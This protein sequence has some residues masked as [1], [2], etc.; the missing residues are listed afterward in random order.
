[1]NAIDA[2]SKAGVKDLEMFEKQ[3]VKYLEYKDHPSKIKE[4]YYLTELKEVKTLNARQKEAIFGLLGTGTYAKRE[5]ELRTLSSARIT[6]AA[7][8]KAYNLMRDPENKKKYG[9]GKNGALTKPD[10]INA[11]QDSGMNYAQALAF[12]K[13][14]R[15]MIEEP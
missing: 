5:L 14:A 6:L 9:S 10:Y 1:M 3:A 12:Y 15:S 8:E 7:Y 2:L 13:V 4:Y 11:A